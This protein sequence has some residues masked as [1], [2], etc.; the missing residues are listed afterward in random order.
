M[1][2]QIAKVV[3]AVEAAGQT[4][5]TIIVF[6]SDHGILIGEHGLHHKTTLYKEVL[7]P[8]L[9]IYDPRGVQAK[10]VSQ[11]VQLLDLVKTALDWGGASSDDKA[12]PYG[13]TLLPIL[14]GQGEFARDYAV[15]ECPGYYAIVTER[16]KYIAPFDYQKDGKIVLFDLEKNPEETINIADQNPELLA[17]FKAK[18]F[19]LRLT[20]SA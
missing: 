14:T 11:P 12:K 1:D 8:A 13:D 19:S 5:N 6:F 16:Y 18:N 3:T 15:G 9:V 17:R 20:S 7:N 4:S 2:D 10:K